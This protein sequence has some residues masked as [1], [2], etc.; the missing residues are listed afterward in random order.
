MPLKSGE[1][2]RCPDSQ[3][4]CEILVTKGASP[5]CSGKENPRCCCGKQM[6]QVE[7]SEEICLVKQQMCSLPSNQTLS[8]ME[9]VMRKKWLWAT[10]SVVPLVIGG[11]VYAGV[12]INADS[13]NN[14]GFVCPITGEG[15][16]CPRCCPLN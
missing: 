13:Q 11:L 3:C 8:L 7:D 16:S 6:V 4:G 10:F 14:A 5:D 12:Q 9:V 1:R 15:L 2:Y